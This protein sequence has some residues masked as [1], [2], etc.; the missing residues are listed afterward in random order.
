MSEVGKTPEFWPASPACEDLVHYS[1]GVLEHNMGHHYLLLVF[2]ANRLFNAA[3][4]YF[5][6]SSLYA[7]Y[8]FNILK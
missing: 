8:A 5:Y 4:K 6:T 1:R 7:K 2:N 3:T